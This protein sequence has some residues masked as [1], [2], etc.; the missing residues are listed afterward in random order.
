MTTQNT[1]QNAGFN[2]RLRD[3][4]ERLNLNDSQLAEYLGV[5]VY[6]VRKWL[7]GTR[8]PAAVAVKL[9]DVLGTLEAVAPAI[10]A[11]LLPAPV[12]KRKSSPEKLAMV[13]NQVSN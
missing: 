6:T 2:A 5:P 13:K 12:V 9:L 4:A 1:P 7:T 10:H 8:T 11:A 3:T